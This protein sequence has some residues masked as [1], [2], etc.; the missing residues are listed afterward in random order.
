MIESYKRYIKH[1]NGEIEENSFNMNN[2][3]A[4]EVK[5]TKSSTTRCWFEKN[6]IIY[7]IVTYSKED[8]VNGNIR[9][10]IENLS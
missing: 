9:F 7:Q 5:N 3:Q 2:L 8:D 6:N 1:E 10:L 4:Y